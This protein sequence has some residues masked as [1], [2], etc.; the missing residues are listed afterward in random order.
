MVELSETSAVFRI[1]FHLTVARLL[2]PKVEFGL[3]RTI[4]KQSEDSFLWVAE[5]VRNEFVKKQSGLLLQFGVLGE[6][7]GENDYM[8]LSI[9]IRVKR[10]KSGI[11]LE[12]KGLTLART[13]A[14]SL[15]NLNFY[16]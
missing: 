12:A 13:I 5:S 11:Y 2:K 4:Q 16:I 10:L 15:K 9:F 1:H 3:V 7:L 14:G 6:K 8:K